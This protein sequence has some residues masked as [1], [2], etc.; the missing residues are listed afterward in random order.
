MSHSKK[1]VPIFG[2]CSDSDKVGKQQANRKF[3]HCIKTR[4]RKNFD[5]EMPLLR[6]FGC[7]GNAKRW[8]VFLG[9]RKAKIFKEV[10]NQFAKLKQASYY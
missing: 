4:L 7:L 10:S 5:L 3:R 1:K 9:R 2:Y 8:K 6:D